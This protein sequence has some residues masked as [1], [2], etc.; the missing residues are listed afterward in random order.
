MQSWQESQHRGCLPV[1]FRTWNIFGALK[2]FRAVQGNLLLVGLAALLG[3]PALPRA[4]A[5][6]EALEL[7]QAAMLITQLV[8]A[9]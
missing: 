1:L 6:P 7:Q 5:L 9:D 8:T 2:N 3:S 4:P